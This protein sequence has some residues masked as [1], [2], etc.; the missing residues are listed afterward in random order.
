MKYRKKPV[1]V[2]AIQWNGF[3]LEEIKEFVGDSLIYEIF[4]TT[5]EGG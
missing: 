1:V 2:E 3:N 5:W 4:D